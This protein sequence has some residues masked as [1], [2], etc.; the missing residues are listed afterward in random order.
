MEVLFRYLE[1]EFSLSDLAMEAGVAKANIFI[2][3]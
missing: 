1:K 2:I 3:L